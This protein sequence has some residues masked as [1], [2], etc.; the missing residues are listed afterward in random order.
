M[1]LRPAE[2]TIE[3]SQVCQSVSLFICPPA[4]PLGGGHLVR[5][6]YRLVGH[7]RL[8]STAGE[9][10]GARKILSRLCALGFSP[11]LCFF[12]SHWTHVQSLPAGVCSCDSWSAELPGGG[13]RGSDRVAMVNSSNWT[14]RITI[15]KVM[16]I[17][18]VT[19]RSRLPC[20]SEQRTRWTSA[21]KRE[22]CI[23]CI[24][25]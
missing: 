23:D 20:R 8:V 11:F 24:D 15:L 22:P 6:S 13:W 1:E 3:I 7:G 5:A 14:A 2:V 10:Q 16:M 4:S 19:P 17:I 9:L 25:E 18:H 12:L 21:F